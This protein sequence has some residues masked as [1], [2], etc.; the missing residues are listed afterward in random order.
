MPHHGEVVRDEQVG[1]AEPVLQ[2]AHQVQDL[3]LDRDVERGGR[4]VADDELGVG[5]E[6]ARDGDALA[7][8]AR[9][10]VRILARRRPG[11]GRRRPSSS[12]TRARIA[13]SPSQQAEG[14]DRLGDDA[15]DPP[16]RIEARIGVLEDHLDAPA[17]APAGRPRRRAPVMATPSIVTRRP[18]S[19]AA[20]RPPCGRRSTCRSRIRRPARRSRRG[21]SSKLTSSTARQE[22][23]RLA[24]R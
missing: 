22:L 17:H 5:G 14:A 13:A 19:A 3:R 7:L 11:A 4:L 6:R 1:Q 9:E 16:A 23:L 12:P 21:R 20:G 10:L 24:A 15:V 2:V 8:A 18:A